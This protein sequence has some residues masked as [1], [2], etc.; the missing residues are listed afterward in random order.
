MI[1]FSRRNHIEKNYR[2]NSITKL[3]KLSYLNLNTCKVVQ[4][5]WEMMILDIGFQYLP[6]VKGIN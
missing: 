1:H 5:F 2:I 6:H 3:L 4:L